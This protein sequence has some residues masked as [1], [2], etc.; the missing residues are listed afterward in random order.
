MILNKASRMFCLTRPF[1][2]DIFI[3]TKLDKRASQ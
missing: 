3:F 1:G 2:F